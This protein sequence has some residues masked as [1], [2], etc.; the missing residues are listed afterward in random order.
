MATEGRA[1]RADAGVGASMA[2]SSGHAWKVSSA[3]VF[4]LAEV[5]E[6]TAAGAQSV[7][8]ETH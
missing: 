1:M 8:I 7:G 4:A 5:K 6:R 2:F 3:L